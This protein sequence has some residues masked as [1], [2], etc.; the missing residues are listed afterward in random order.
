LNDNDVS[1][2]KALEGQI[3]GLTLA[4]IRVAKA[5]PDPAAVAA[6]LEIASSMFNDGSARS[7]GAALMLRLIS[8]AI[9]QEGGDHIEPQ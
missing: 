2:L 3:A 6:E 4:I 1:L 8:N 5:C 7:E 9:R